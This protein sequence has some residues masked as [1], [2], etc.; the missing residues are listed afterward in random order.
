MPTTR[1][2][3]SR[4]KFTDRKIVVKDHDTDINIVLPDGEKM[5][6]QFRFEGDFPSLDICFDKQREVTNWIEGMKP[7]PAVRG[8]PETRNAY[9]LCIM[10]DP[11]GKPYPKT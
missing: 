4:Y 10:L 11:K 9:Q 1:P 5:V 6:L 7:A 8:R 2:Y 3:K